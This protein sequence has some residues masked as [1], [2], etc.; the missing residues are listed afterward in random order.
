MRA[1][2]GQ[3]NAHPCATVE[4]SEPAVHDRYRPA[5]LIAAVLTIGALT[6]VVSA[7]TSTP[8]PAE[9]L[10]RQVEASGVEQHRAGTPEPEGAMSGVPGEHDHAHSHGDHGHIPHVKIHRVPDHDTFTTAGV[11]V[12]DDPYME[13]VEKFWDFDNVVM[14]GE[15]SPAC[16]DELRSAE[17]ADVRFDSVH[18]RSIDCLAWWG[19][20][21]GTPDHRF[22]GSTPI[23]REQN[24]SLLLRTIEY[25]GGFISASVPPSDIR[26]THADAAGALVHSGIMSVRGDG[27]FAPSDGLRRDEMAVSLVAAYETITGRQAPSVAV[28]FDDLADHPHAEVIA[29]AYELGFTT[30]VS[31]TEFGPDRIVTRAQMASFLTRLLDKLAADGDAAMPGD[32]FWGS[33]P[34]GRKAFLP[35][36]TAQQG[37]YVPMDPGGPSRLNPCRGANVY[38]NY[39][40]APPGAREAVQTAVQRV[41]AATGI[42]LRDAGLTDVRAPDPDNPSDEARGLNPE[43]GS[44]T[45][46]WPRTWGMPQMGGYAEVWFGPNF[47][48]AGRIAINPALRGEDLTQILMHELGHTVGLGHPAGDGQVMSSYSSIRGA[49]WQQ[50]DLAGLALAGRGGGC[51]PGVN[52]WN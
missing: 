34:P 39:S 30:G 31:D 26:G 19:I 49:Q 22:A 13:W 1:G 28:P 20:S 45:I 23:T 10:V 14:P 48:V 27:S 38:V 9:P 17:F 25:A 43:L 29:Q 42:D 12:D 7:L 3:V 46:S 50:G 5:V 18:A 40:D 35:L 8:N 16:T 4:P 41:R 36:A 37:S 32:P 47:I 24:A 52:P 11:G 33:V 44:I 6:L 51:E 2:D 15:P 21:V